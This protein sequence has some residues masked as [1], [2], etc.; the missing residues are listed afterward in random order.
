MTVSLPALDR[1]DIVSPEARADI[2]RRYREMRAHGPLHRFTDPFSGNP[3]WVALSHEAASEVLRDTTTFIRDASLLPGAKPRPPGPRGLEMIT[4][5][6]VHH[7][8]QFANAEWSMASV[9][10]DSDM[11]TATRARVYGEVADQ[12]VLVI[13]THFAGVTAGR[14]RKD[15]ASYRFDAEE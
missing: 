6:M 1:F 4:G 15:G 8:F 9:D 11:A 13:G 2:H 5:D 7:P 10:Y 12:P 3:A 14:V